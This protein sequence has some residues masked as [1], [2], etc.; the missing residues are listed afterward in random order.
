[1]ASGPTCVVGASTSPDDSK[2]PLE[3][4]T[5]PLAGS[6]KGKYGVGRAAGAGACASSWT[7][8]TTIVVTAKARRSW[9]SWTVGLGVR[10]YWG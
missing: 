7:S 6:P 1:M 4:R 2:E 5:T 3:G 10:G 9:A 8:E